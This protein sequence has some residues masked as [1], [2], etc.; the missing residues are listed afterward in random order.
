[1]ILSDYLLIAFFVWQKSS[2]FSISAYAGFVYMTILIT[3]NPLIFCNTVF[4]WSARGTVPIT[5]VIHRMLGI[6]LY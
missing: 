4:E 2:L 3:L 5:V 6:G 1:M